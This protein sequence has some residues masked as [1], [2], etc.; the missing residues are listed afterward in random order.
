MIFSID[1]FFLPVGKPR[2]SGPPPN[3]PK[4]G[5]PVSVGN[6]QSASPQY[7]GW[8]FATHMSQV[9]PICGLGLRHP[10]ILG[11]DE[12]VGTLWV[13]CGYDVDTMWT[14]RDPAD[15]GRPRRRPHPEMWAPDFLPRY[16]WVKI[17]LPTS[18]DVGGAQTNPHIPQS[19]F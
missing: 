15:V 6:S 3:P 17:S 1:D 19:S 14:G 7:V 5:A 12:D 10:H 13:R 16:I 11:E 4:T 9:A 2:F 8:G 18:S